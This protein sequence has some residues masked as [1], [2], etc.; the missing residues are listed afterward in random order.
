M[1]DVS[2]VILGRIG[3]RIIEVSKNYKR[4]PLSAFENETNYQ[5][6]LVKRSLVSILKNQKMSMFINLS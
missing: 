1:C 3:L 5:K 6:M 4:N 2:Q